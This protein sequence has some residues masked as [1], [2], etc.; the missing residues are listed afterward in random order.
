VRFE[1][2]MT[3]TLEPGQ[4]MVSYPV[5]LQV[6]AFSELAITFL[7]KQGESLT[8]H[9]S[10]QQT[11]YVSGIGDVSLTPGEVTFLAYPLLSPSRWLITSSDVLPVCSAQYRR[12]LRHFYHRWLWLDPECELALARLPGQPSEGCRWHTLHVGR[13]S[14]HFRLEKDLEYARR[15]M[16]AGVPTELHVY[17]GV[18]HGS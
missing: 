17:P 18:I 14:G 1:G 8:G 5:A 12:G 16:R 7:L 10:A 3:V 4:K 13:Q 2:D 11:S 6:E 9:A 15:L